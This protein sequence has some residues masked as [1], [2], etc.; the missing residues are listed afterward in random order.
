MSTRNSRVD[1]HSHC[2]NYR[3]NSPGP[4]AGAFD[5]S[6]FSGDSTSSSVYSFT[7]PLSYN[8]GNPYSSTSPTPW[9][10]VS[11]YYNA[12]G[13]NSTQNGMGMFSAAPSNSSQKPWSQT[14]RGKELLAFGRDAAIDGLSGVPGLG[15]EVVAADLAAGYVNT[16]INANNST[17]WTF[18]GVGTSLALAGKPSGVAALGKT[19]GQLGVRAGEAIPFL[20]AIV[21]V[22]AV[23]NDARVA[24]NEYMNCLKNGG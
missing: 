17:G 11:L 6:D 19:F 18:Q 20:G 7:G 8:A 4:L 10:T 21:A 12:G 2:S 3:A 14:C 16:V 22:G 13:T 5:S 23:L 15:D 1:L 24:G 9:F